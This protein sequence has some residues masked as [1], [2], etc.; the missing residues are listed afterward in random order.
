[1][2]KILLLII[3]LLFLCGEG[4]S[5]SSESLC[6]GSELVAVRDT[7]VEVMTKCSKPSFL[8]KTS[9]RRGGIEKWYYDRSSADLVY[10]LI[11]HD[12]ILKYVEQ[13]GR[14]K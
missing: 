13:A 5:S 10:V 1:M 2:K 7:K 6:C 9:S 11:F 8:E 14:G 4:H 3:I 12:G